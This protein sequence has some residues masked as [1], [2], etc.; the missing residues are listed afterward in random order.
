MPYSNKQEFNN[1]LSTIRHH[2]ANFK[3]EFEE[4][5]KNTLES[6]TT[7]FDHSITVINQ[8]IDLSYD[9]RLMNT[10]AFVQYLS[11]CIPHKLIKNKDNKR[12]KIFTARI[13]KEGKKVPYLTEEEMNEYIASTD[14]WRIKDSE[15]KDK[16]EITNALMAEKMEKYLSNNLKK[17]EGF[18]SVEVESIMNHFKGELKAVMAHHTNSVVVEEENKTKRSL[19][20]QINSLMSDEELLA[21]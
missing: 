19:Q 2:S 20:D 15:K 10:T 11:N 8:L 18:T 9:S 21:A 12:R 16:P 4:M 5:V 3:Y 17:M 13:N 14:I 1:A 7:N 6:Y